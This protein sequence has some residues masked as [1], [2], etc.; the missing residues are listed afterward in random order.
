MKRYISYGILLFFI[1]ISTAWLALAGVALPVQGSKHDLS[2]S[3]PGPIKASSSGATQ[4]CVFC[5]TPH[6]AR[7]DAPL[8][9]RSGGSSSYALYNKAFSDV[10]SQLGGGSYPDAE[11]PA[12][13][14]SPGYPVH[15][16]T[17]ICL[18]CH[19]GTI[20]LGNLVN[21][22][23]PFTSNIPMAGA[24]AGGMMPPTATGYIG[25][26]LSDDHPVAIKHNAGS[27]SGMDP[28][29]KNPITGKVRL[30]SLNAQNRTQATNNNGDYVECTSCHDAHD[31][32]Y[33]NFLIDDNAG[34]KIC[35]SCHS[36][37]GYD[38][39]T[40][41]M[42]G[43]SAEPY[44]PTTGG[45]PAT[46]GN[47]V[48]GVK[49]MDCHYPHKAGVSAYGGAANSPAGKY[50]LTYQEEKSC[51]N[52]TNR[53]NQTTGACH[54]L[55]ASAPKRNIESLVNGSKTFYHAVSNWPNKHQATEASLSVPP[56]SPWL[57]AGNTN[58]HVECVDCH[59]P[60]IAG[61]TNHAPGTNTISSS[62][63]LYGTQGVVPGSYPVW[64]NGTGSYS[65]PAGNLGAGVTNYSE[66]GAQYEYQICLKCHS[67]FAWGS[68]PPTVTINNTSTPSL[69]LPLTNQAMEFGNNATSRHPVIAQSGNALYSAAYVAPWT[70]NGFQ[71]MYCSDCHTN[72]VATPAGPHGSSYRAIVKKPYDPASTMTTGSE[73]CYDCHKF[74]T[75]Y[76][77]IDPLANT[78]FRNA[79]YNLHSRHMLP[80][81][82][83]GVAYQGGVA[84]TC[85]GCHVNPPHGINRQHM[86]SYTTDPAPYNSYTKV[87]AYTVNTGNY[88]AGNCSAV[89]CHAGSH[90]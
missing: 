10:L 6:S 43:Q 32:Q 20:A 68:T 19:D 18:S 90:P 83:G 60:H 78:G 28:E 58:W 26:D 63:P 81:A 23:Y 79:T 54:A 49:C 2:F 7:A 12:S 57:G 53:W 88:I 39:V 25:L 69:P 33:G 56:S 75:Y 77:G 24:T 44:S 80:A 65:V 4:I 86:I 84:K 59:N 30:Y 11:D 14:S 64:P 22:P 76:Q 66:T 1:S 62:S 42:H 48:A 47:D 87:I 74:T 72:D 29:L 51:F 52:A 46:L 61:Q 3:G 8:W 41:G 35:V 70:N 73:L 21:L 71:T 9:N 13:V 89:T 34:S 67:D 36:K 38:T 5:H 37:A 85:T 45:T 17:R 31:N 40:T 16:K 15:V 50:L 55:N 27:G 82:S